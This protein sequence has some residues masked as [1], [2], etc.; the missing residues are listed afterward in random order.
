MASRQQ[1]SLLR[2]QDDEER[3]YDMALRNFQS[4]AYRDWPNEA[5]V[6]D[7]LIMD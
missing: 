7:E 4:G 2:N 3:D 5:G 1:A 6:S